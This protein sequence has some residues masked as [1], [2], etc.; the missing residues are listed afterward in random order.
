MSFSLMLTF[1]TN[2]SLLEIIASIKKEMTTLEYVPLKLFN[3]QF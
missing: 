1:F 2:I 3:F